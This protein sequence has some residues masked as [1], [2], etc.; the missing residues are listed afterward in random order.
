LS[1]L[2]KKS[3]MRRNFPIVTL[4]AAFSIF[5]PLSDLVGHDGLELLKHELSWFRR[6]CL[7]C[8]FSPVSGFCAFHPEL[9]QVPGMWPKRRLRP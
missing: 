4:S 1:I 5:S 3:I 2:S 7:V 6:L 8:R 9:R